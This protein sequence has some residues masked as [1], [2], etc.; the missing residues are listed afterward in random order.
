MRIKIYLLITIL[1]VLITSCSN[2]D[3]NIYKEPFTGGAG[4]YTCGQDVNGSEINIEGKN[5]KMFKNGNA[6]NLTDNPTS[7]SYA[8]SIIINGNDVYVAGSNNWIAKVWKNGIKVDLEGGETSEVTD[9]FVV[10]NDV[11]VS[12][13]ASKDLP[14]PS[15]VQRVPIYW[16]NGVA[17]SLLNNNHYGKANSIFVSGTDVYVSGYEN[18][19]ATIW[20]NGIPIKLSDGSQSA[21]VIDVVVVAN[22]IYAIGFD[23][24][25]AKFWK[26]GVAINLSDGQSSVLLKKIVVVGQDVYIGGEE[27]SI[28]H[29]AIAK[30]WKNGVST[31]LTDGTIWAHFSSM[32]VDASN[33]VYMV[34][35]EPVDKNNVTCKIW[36]NGVVINKY[37][38]YQF[39][40]DIFVVT[41]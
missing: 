25:M 10:G 20:K 29:P 12:G 35:N 7:F 5:A 11:Y 1:F 28:S 38:N 39:I 23:N 27:N 2:N 37:N 16:K 31:N 24:N 26:N 22:D 4:I 18:N 32:F 13:N 21:S 14:P 36:K 40:N 34:T 8:Q 30:I 41:N 6:F 17:I 19:T 3:N 15:G 9:M 33:N